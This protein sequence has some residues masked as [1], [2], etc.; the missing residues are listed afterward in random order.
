MWARGMNFSWVFIG[1]KSQRKGPPG[2]SG[3]AGDGNEK[4]VLEAHFLSTGQMAK[5][6]KDE[7]RMMNY[8]AVPKV[9]EP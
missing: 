6:K 1:N 3:D 5:P 9:T 4:T 8:E 7:G 2:M